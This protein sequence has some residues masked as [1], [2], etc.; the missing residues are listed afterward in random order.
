MTA[1]YA[2]KL[3]RLIQC[4]MPAKAYQLEGD[5]QKGYV[6]SLLRAFDKVP[7][8]RFAKYAEP[9]IYTMTTIPAI[10][11]FKK[12]LST[13]ARQPDPF[14]LNESDIRSIDGQHKV[15]TAV[16]DILKSK[17]WGKKHQLSLSQDLIAFAR[18]YFPRITEAEITRNY[19]EIAFAFNAFKHPNE[20]ER[21]VLH[22]SPDDG[23]IYCAISAP[24]YEG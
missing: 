15:P 14:V 23:Y 2:G 4:A 16:K 3:V 8:E 19:S 18:K 22:R 20:K 13:A 11:D 9:I 5:R 24:A 1:Q 7:D 21:V 10:G 12:A 17:G 6:F